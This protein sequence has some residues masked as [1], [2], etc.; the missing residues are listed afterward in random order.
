MNLISAF[1]KKNH[2]KNKFL[3]W[4]E[5][6]FIKNSKH[7]SVIRDDIIMVDYSSSYDFS[8]TYFNGDFAICH[9]GFVII[10]SCLVQ[11]QCLMTA[12]NYS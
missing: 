8:L 3:I 4:G 1:T 7:G 11:A 6:G 10:N 5:G 12:F 9:E 2:F